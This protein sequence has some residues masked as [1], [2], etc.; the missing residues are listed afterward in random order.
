MPAS[1]QRMTE[2]LWSLPLLM[3]LKKSLALKTIWSSGSKFG[4]MSSAS[5][6]AE[7][8]LPVPVSPVMTA[9]QFLFLFSSLSLIS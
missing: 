1:S 6:R 4:S 7:K 5:L 9:I 3:S 8:L 2:P